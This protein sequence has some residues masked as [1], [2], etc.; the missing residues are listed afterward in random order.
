M[1]YKLMD[2]NTLDEEMIK[3][4][5]P[6]LT[7][8]RQ[9]KIASMKSSKERA[10]A[11]CAEIISRQCLSQFC[12]A[13]EFSFSLL[14]NPNSRSVVGNF[15]VEICIVQ[16]DEYVACAVSE[17]YVGISIVPVQS[18]S[19]KDAQNLLSDSE[20]RSVFSDSVYSFA[21]LINFSECLEENVKQKFAIYSSLKEAHYFSTGRG[22]RSEINK[23]YFE[24]NKN[25]IICS[26]ENSKVS[27]SFINNDY[28]LAVSVV[29][30]NKI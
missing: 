22:V 26:D 29:E 30:R 12:D 16:Y 24:I 2:I 6:M 13:P 17:D 4:Y 7:Q 20:I 23:T 11:F 8:A 5:F 19:F 10:V 3:K 14:C 28:S 27:L 21:E 15:N 1:I 25:G 9:K 18:F